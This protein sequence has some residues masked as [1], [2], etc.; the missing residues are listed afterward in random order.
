MPVLSNVWVQRGTQGVSL[1]C[2][3]G[4]LHSHHGHEGQKWTSDCKTPGGC[5][6]GVGVLESRG[7]HLAP[8]RRLKMCGPLLTKR[9]TENGNTAENRAFEFKEHFQL[10]H[11]GK[12]EMINAPI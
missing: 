1:S 11:P 8:A 10:P 6:S 4:T 9:S 5:G 7:G 3:Y 12:E 2:S